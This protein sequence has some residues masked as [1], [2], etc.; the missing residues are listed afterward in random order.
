MCDI[1][2]RLKTSIQQAT[3]INIRRKCMSSNNAVSILNRKPATKVTHVK[4]SSKL[5]AGAPWVLCFWRGRKQNFS[6]NTFFSDT[7][8]S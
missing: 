6:T 8:N 5:D 3:G 4:T 2:Q 1:M 7:D